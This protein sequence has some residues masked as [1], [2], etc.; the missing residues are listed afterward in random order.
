MDSEEMQS[1]PKPDPLDA[2]VYE[3]LHALGVIVLLHGLFLVMGLADSLFVLKGYIWI[4]CCLLPLGSIAAA[5]VLRFSGGWH[6]GQIGLFMIASGVLS[7][8]QLLLIGH[9]T[10]G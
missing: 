9:A 8:I 6:W 10:A 5:A 2:E 1:G 3:V 4:A 7:F